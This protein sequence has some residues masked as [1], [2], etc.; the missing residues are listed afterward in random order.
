MALYKIK[1][2][3][4]DYRDH[5][6]QDILGFDLYSTDEK[7]GSVD[8]LLVDEQGRFRYL[9]INTGV[10]IFGK[11]VLL[12]IG[13]SRIS[14]SDRRVY[15][16]GLSREQVEHLPEYDESQTV[17]YEHEERVR[18]V[19][20]P[21]ATS[22]VESPITGNA[23][24]NRSASL[25]ES[26]PLNMGATPQQRDVVS[27]RDLSAYD[28]NTYSYDR[29]PDLYNLDERNH[30]NLRLYEERLIA[31]KTRQKTGEVR[32][33]K[34]VETETARVS[35]PI[36]K[37]RVVIDR[38]SPVDAVATPGAGD[39]HEGEVARIEVYEETP[40]IRKEA[41]VR[42]E[43]RVRKEVDRQNVDAEETLRK[44]RLD[45]DTDGNPIVDRGDRI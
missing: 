15:A 20:R 36:E 18:G 37:E 17:D 45:I 7:V 32:V 13:Q 33:G 9:V 19:Y 44:E 31:N 28:R 22:R 40:D 35:V 27:D 5:F 38:T 30:Q 10:W 42:E 3:D 26:A 11:K 41:F 4:P 6:D 12:P 25:D 2:F 34:H 29:D 1:D 23:P 14:F 21:M 16:D 8:N 24:I 39:F 43:V